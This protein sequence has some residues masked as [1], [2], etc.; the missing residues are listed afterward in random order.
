LEAEELIAGVEGWDQIRTEAD[1]RADTVRES[2]FFAFFLEIRGGIT[3]RNRGYK[4]R[5]RERGEEQTLT[6]RN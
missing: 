6:E 4:R 1:I 3:A 2:F 5:E